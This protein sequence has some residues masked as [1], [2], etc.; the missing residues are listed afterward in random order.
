M[1]SGRDTFAPGLGAKTVSLRL[2]T[3]SQLRY[4]S[5]AMSLHDTPGPCRLI[6]NLSS[7]SVKLRRFRRTLTPYAQAVPP[8]ACYLL[9]RHQ[10]WQNHEKNLL[11]ACSPRYGGIGTR[12]AELSR[13]CVLLYVTSPVMISNGSGETSTLWPVLV[14]VASYECHRLRNFQAPCCPREHLEL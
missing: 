1:L 3:V 5:K 9:D 14:H 8:R 4:N 10:S 11:W 7:S 2:T 13:G 6:I 12:F